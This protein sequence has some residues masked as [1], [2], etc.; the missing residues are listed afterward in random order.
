MGKKAISDEESEDGFSGDS[1]SE[2]EENLKKK[3]KI[4]KEEKK[5]PAVEKT[6]SSHSTKG[7][8]STTD[9]VPVQQSSS[10]AT[11]DISRGPPV[12]NEAAAKKLIILYL[13]TQNRPYSALQI[14]DN[15]HKRIQKPVIERILTALSEGDVEDHIIKC[16]EYGK[17][18]IYYYNQ[19]MLEAELEQEGTTNDAGA[20][21]A[22]KEKLAE[23]QSKNRELKATADG[24]A[25]EP[26]DETLIKYVKSVVDWICGGCCE[27][28]VGISV[29]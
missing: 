16:K 27:W 12:T 13:K 10:I 28:C 21:E 8:E 1:D 7:N 26:D 2:E 25:N 20:I 6:K 4:S 22:L 15:L 11:N 23:L 18:K 14:H 24:L 3:Q 29:S 17:A 9:I 19:A 5:K